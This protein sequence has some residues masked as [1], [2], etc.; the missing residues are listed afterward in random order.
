MGKIVTIGGVNPPS[1][2][3]L[4]DKEIIKLTNKK[5]PKILY[6]PT[7]GGD[8]LG[9]CDFYRGIYEGRFGC[10]MDVLFLINQTPT[11][12]E[13]REKILSSDI[14]YVGGGSV[15][16]LLEVLEKFKVID[17]LKEAYEKGIVFAGISAGALCWGLNYFYTE[18]TEGFKTIEGFSEY[19][20][21][22][23]IGYLPFVICPHYN[24]EG[25]K[26][27]MDS[28]IEEFELPG[29]AIDNNCAVEFVD[30]TYRVISTSSEANAYKVFKNGD[31]V[32]S[33]VIKKNVDF[34]PIQELL[35]S[36]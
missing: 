16:K 6:V 31:G 17:M 33:Q 29:I 21:V 30:G 18:Y 25:Y 24:L 32:V 3:D 2:L 4:I 19:T 35:M 22:E 5:Y 13:I 26:E 27:K 23:C 36:I 15:V 20:K 34:R 12:K 9:Y 7:A 8:N 14:I 1:S 11:E 28:M 10:E